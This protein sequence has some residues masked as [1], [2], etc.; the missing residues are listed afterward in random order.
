MSAELLGD[1][2][3]DRLALPFLQQVRAGRP[4]DL[5]LR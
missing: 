1:E 3:E 2:A 4:R 5:R